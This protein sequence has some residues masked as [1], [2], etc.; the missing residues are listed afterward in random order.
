MLGCLIPNL[1]LT[2]S[3]QVSLLKLGLTYL[4]GLLKEFTETTYLALVLILPFLPY[5]I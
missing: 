5:L 2:L 4:V 1:S 3:V